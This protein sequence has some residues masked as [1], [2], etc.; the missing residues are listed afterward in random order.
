LLEAPL[1]FR[2]AGVV[3]ATL[4]L[5]FLHYATDDQRSAILHDVL[6]RVGS[7]P[8]VD[9]V[10][11]GGRLPFTPW[12]VTRRVGRAEQPDI[13]GIVSTQQSTVEGYLRVMGTPLLQGRD[14]NAEDFTAKRP[15]AIVDDRLAHRLWPEGAL[16]KRLFYRSG[17]TIQE[18]EIVGVTAPVRAT[19]VRDE[20]VPH[21]FVPY[22]VY[23]IELSLVIKTRQ[24]AA[25]LAP[26]I[27]RA[28]LEANTGRAAFDIRPMSSYVDDSIGDT[29]FLLVVLAAFACA[30]VLLASVGLY[31]TLAYLISQRTREFGI[32]MAL[33][34]GIA[35]IVGMVV[36]EG[37]LLTASGVALGMAGALAVAGAIR[38]F[39]YN[40]AP[41]DRLTLAGVIGLLAMV[42]L[43]A[44]A[45]PAWRA[46]RIDP[47][48]T[49]RG[50]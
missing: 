43:C 8:G 24:S 33:G 44:A 3:T 20:E 39:L 12:Q 50:D 11:A 35:V 42:A 28:A 22:H 47:N 14:F 34:S 10:S 30:C 23:P 17:R 7:V 6:R 31:G 46:A 48:Q 32:R 2:P 4:P 25:A 37:A 29:R 27:R 41:F 18:L 45:A 21:F 13:P 36:R 9:S 49:L 1:G 19:R 38:Q 15:V 5:N 16:G 40:V 26:A